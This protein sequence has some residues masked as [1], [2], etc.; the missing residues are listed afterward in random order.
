MASAL[1]ANAGRSRRWPP[2]SC[3]AH[4]GVAARPRHGRSRRR[5]RRAGQDAGAAAPRIERPRRG[6][7]PPLAC[8]AAAARIDRAR[9]ACVALPARRRPEVG[10]Q[11]AE[12]L[13]EH[14]VAAC[15]AYVVTTTRDAP[16]DPGPPPS[17]ADREV[18]STSGSS[19]APRYSSWSTRWCS[20]TPGRPGR[21]PPAATPR[22]CA[23]RGSCRAMEYGMLARRRVM[24]MGIDRLLMALTGSGFGKRSS[25]RSGRGPSGRGRDLRNSN[26]RR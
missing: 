17:R 19:W 9:T 2:P 14:L 4:S 3:G 11:L 1:P 20:A 23:R 8:S 21:R 12:E 6:G 18:D 22:R 5:C 25:S 16:A 7:V 13:F 24:G 10:R 15:R 26:T